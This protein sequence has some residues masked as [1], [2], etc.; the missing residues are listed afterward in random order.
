MLNGLSKM[1]KKKNGCHIQFYN[2]IEPEKLHLQ[3]YK[4]TCTLNVHE[5]IRIC[6]CASNLHTHTHTHTH[7]RT[8]THTHTHTHKSE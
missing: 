6:A 8:H 1:A 4:K 2:S 3:V 7:T 5:R